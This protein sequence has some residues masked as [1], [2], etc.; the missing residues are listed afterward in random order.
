MRILPIG[1]GVMFSHLH[2]P[3][4]Q[5]F[6]NLNKEMLLSI[7]NLESEIPRTEM[8][9]NI[10]NLHHLPCQCLDF[11]PASEI[12]A[13]PMESAL[14]SLKVFLRNK[15]HP[16]ASMFVRHLENESVRL[17][18]DYFSRNQATQ[19]QAGPVETL[20][21]SGKPTCI[22]LSEADIEGIKRYISKEW[23]EFSSVA[24]RLGI[25][26][27]EEQMVW[28]ASRALDMSQMRQF[29]AREKSI[30]GGINPECMR[31]KKFNIYRTKFTVMTDMGRDN[32][33]VLISHQSQ[34][35][36]GTIQDI[37]L[38]EVRSPYTLSDN[39]HQLISFNKYFVSHVHR[40]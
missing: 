8:V 25:D 7:C 16:A 37:A 28:D 26:L 38:I 11:G 34:E 36:V 13:Y 12:W 15:A 39:I 3:A 20:T 10:H 1:S 2:C 33:K 6:Q 31:L 27:S 23:K 9:A 4:L 21:P 35:I 29:T 14:G 24:E 30:A 19:F 5:E 18:K 40:C 22:K 17:I 32:S